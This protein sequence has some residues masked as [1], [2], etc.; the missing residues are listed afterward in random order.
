MRAK[1][2]IQSG[3]RPPG[4]SKATQIID[5]QAKMYER[6]GPKVI[7]LLKRCRTGEA[8]EARDADKLIR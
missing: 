8:I 6:I 3:L 4:R 5:A 7:R 1:G 2:C